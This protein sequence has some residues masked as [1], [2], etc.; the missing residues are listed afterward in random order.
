MRHSLR[1]GAAACVTVL[2]LVGFAGCGDKTAADAG[3]AT[4]PAKAAPK[5]TTASF[6]FK[7]G[8]VDAKSLANRMSK[9]QQGLK[10][11]RSD[12]TFDMTVDGSSNTV[13][14]GGD[15]DQ[16]D[17]K[18]PSSHVTTTVG[19]KST[20]VVVAG[21]KAWVKTGGKWVGADAGKATQADQAQQMSKWAEAA[22]SAD[23]KG[24]DATGHH[25]VIKLKPS[26]M[27]ADPD[28]SVDA[29]L[30]DVPADYWTD[31]HLA[32]LK[33]S[34]KMS[35]KSSS[36]DGTDVIRIVMTMSRFNV[37]VTIPKVA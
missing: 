35:E 36:G 7:E 20:E 29:E 23:Y 11:Y 21:S 15:V 24:E 6:P 14:F 25:F 10:S 5:A 34:M 32:P 26:K 2:A 4:S 18:K 19:G 27:M 16:S 13:K 37:P 8:A 33:V 3:A 28:A 22:T 1:R 9:A 17:P 12:G 31:D 30:G